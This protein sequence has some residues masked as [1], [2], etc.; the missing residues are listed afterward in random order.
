MLRV[1]VSFGKTLRQWDR[2]QV[3]LLPTIGTIN[4]KGLYGYTYFFVNFCWLLWMMSIK[5]YDSKYNTK[6]YETIGI[7]ASALQPGI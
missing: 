2:K 6:K 1:K 3:F 7:R 4:L 5:V